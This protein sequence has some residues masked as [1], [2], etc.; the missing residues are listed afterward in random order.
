MQ[1]N[2]V[3][4]LKLNKEE[5]KK[6]TLFNKKMMLFSCKNFKTMKHVRCSFCMRRQCDVSINSKDDDN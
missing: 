2:I 3:N 6:E 5:L 4:K 1:K